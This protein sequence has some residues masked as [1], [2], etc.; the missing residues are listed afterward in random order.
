[1]FGC[2]KFPD[3]VFLFF[4]FA[5]NLTTEMKP[6]VTCLWMIDTDRVSTMLT[7]CALTAFPFQHSTNH[8]RLLF[9]KTPTRQIAIFYCQP[10]SI[11]TT[12]KRQIFN[13][14]TFSV[15]I[16]FHLIDT[17]WVHLTPKHRLRCENKQT[18]KQT[19]TQKRAVRASSFLL[20]VCIKSASRNFLAKSRLRL[21]SMGRVL[22]GKNFHFIFNFYFLFYHFINFLWESRV[23][24]PE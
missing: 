19:N 4:N 18:S 16:V 21:S 3:T 7:D 1:M 20:I 8:L 17:A 6:I 22:K 12:K 2:L 14:R 9:N 13:G 15:I 10:R 5:G 24:L 11:K 23:A